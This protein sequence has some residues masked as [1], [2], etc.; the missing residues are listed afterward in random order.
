MLRVRLSRG[1]ARNNAFY[2]V[3]VQEQ[4]FQ[5]D[6]KY[7]EKIGYYNPDKTHREFKLDHERY[8]YWVNKGAQPSTTVKSLVRRLSPS[9]QN[10]TTPTK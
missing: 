8:Q 2:S 1:G 10:T 4:D 5:R 3:V 7:I 9:S 6:G